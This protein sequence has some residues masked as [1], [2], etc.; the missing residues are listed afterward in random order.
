MN[1]DVVRRFESLQIWRSGGTRA[2]H[3]PLLLLWALGRC[4]HG[5]PRLTPFDHVD[6]ELRKLLY[7][8]GPH[9]K[10]IHTEDPF[11]RLQNDGVWEID[12][13]D[14]VRKTPDG[15]GAFK[16]DLRKYSIQGGFREDDYLEFRSDPNLIF[17]VAGSLVSS[18]FPITLHD[19]IFEATLGESHGS[20]GMEITIEDDWVITKQRR[21]NP[22]FREK[23]L[24][25]YGPRCAVCEFAGELDG[26]PLALEAAHIKWH[27]AKGP[28]IVENGLVLCS[29]HHRL[30]DKGAFTLSPKLEVIVAK[31]VK[32]EG[33]VNSLLRFDQATLKGLS[34][35]H[36]PKPDMGFLAWHRSEVFRIR[37]AVY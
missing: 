20:V 21:R 14:R 13:P 29:L 17:R 25:A 26:R 35:A 33:V 24:A 19:E 31:T 36:S 3:K 11:W 32:G 7:R 16:S 34:L 2:P 30:F 18:H 9:R 5:H 37:D 8:F 6:I 1:E 23:V 4:L 12:R 28:A 10:T 22:Y 15:S 27:E